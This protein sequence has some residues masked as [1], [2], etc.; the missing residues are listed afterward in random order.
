[1][2]SREWVE[3][4][5]SNQI[6]NANSGKGPD[7]TAGYGYYFWRCARDKAYRGDGWA[8]QYVI[9]LPEQDACIGIMSHDFNKQGIMDCVWE[10]VV[11]QL[12]ENM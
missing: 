10:H 2:V 12:K 9:V 4:A 7:S 11:P 3:Q 6:S 8:G 1:M 5:T